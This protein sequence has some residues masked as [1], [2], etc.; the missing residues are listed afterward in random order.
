MKISSGLCSTSQVRLYCA[1]VI[2]STRLGI[3]IHILSPQ[4]SDTHLIRLAGKD[5]KH[6]QGYSDAAP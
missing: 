6:F 3:F 1:V 4:S 2:V 5:M